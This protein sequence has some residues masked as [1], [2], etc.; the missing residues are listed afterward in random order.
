[1]FINHKI[2]RIIS[3]QNDTFA[4]KAFKGKTLPSYLVYLMNDNQAIECYEEFGIANK[5]Q[6]ILNLFVQNCAWSGNIDTLELEVA[7]HLL[8]LTPA[9]FKKQY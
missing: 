9:E 8:E 6:R 4:S 5:E 7:E 2:M 1:M 3:K